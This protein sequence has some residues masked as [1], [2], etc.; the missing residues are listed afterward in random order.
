MGEAITYLDDEG[1]QSYERKCRYTLLQGYGIM[2]H[3]ALYELL[4]LC[5]F[6][7]A[8]AFHYSSWVAWH[9]IPGYVGIMISSDLSGSNHVSNICSM[10]SLETNSLSA[11][12]SQTLFSLRP[13]GHGV[14]QTGV[15]RSKRSGIQQQTN[16]WCLVLFIIIVI[17]MEHILVDHHSWS[18]NFSAIA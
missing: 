1:G 15:C 6:E 12:F 18:T 10:Q 5:S 9:Q 7:P 17:Q 3:V 14:T 11:E 8:L 13:L 16:F 2:V 4:G